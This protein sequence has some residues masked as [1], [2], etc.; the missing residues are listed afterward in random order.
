LIRNTNVNFNKSKYSNFRIITKIEITKTVPTKCLAVDSLNHTYLAGLNLIKTHN[1]N[2]KITKTS[3]F[4]KML[5]PLN[6][7]DCV[8]YEHYRLQINTYAWLLEQAGFIPRY[9][10]FTHINV[11]YRFDYSPKEVE[12]MLIHAGLLEEKYDF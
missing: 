9:L 10:G 12:L 7:L 3:I 6:Y 4:G 2:K 8:N 11:P 5:P 1:T